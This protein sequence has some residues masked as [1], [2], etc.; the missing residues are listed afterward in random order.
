MSYTRLFLMRHGE[1]EGGH[2]F[3]GSTDVALS[4]TG[5]QTVAHAAGAL[6]ELQAIYSS[7]LRR[8]C[9]FAERLAGARQ[10]TVNTDERLREMHFGD[11]EG[12]LIAEVE[13]ADSAHFAA[14][15]AN[16]ALATPP[17]GE[18]LAAMAERA[19]AA[20]AD[21]AST[22]SGRTVLVLCHGGVIRALLCQLLDMP[23]AAAG[24]L[25]VPY[26]SLTEISQFANTWGTGMHLVRH[27]FANAGG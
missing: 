4:E 9:A 12:R 8:C 6:P 13:A 1:C 17:N 2:I 20:L 18:T 7:P 23:L 16:P 22:E 15:R 24:R 3:R 19:G 25:Y 10:L 11:W 5:W 26:G 14:W 21:I 27:N